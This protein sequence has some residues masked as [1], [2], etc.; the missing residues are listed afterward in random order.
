MK[1]YDVYVKLSGGSVLVE[2]IEAEDAKDAKR[3]VLEKLLE[4]R[5]HLPESHPGEGL[6]EIEIYELV[7]VVTID[8][9]PKITIL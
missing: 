9:R 6:E 3:Q 4:L 7:K 2:P 8:L 5:K 1:G